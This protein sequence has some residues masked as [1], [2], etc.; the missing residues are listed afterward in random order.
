MDGIEAVFHENVGA[1]RCN[2][3]DLITERS[4]ATSKMVVSSS[5]FG[6]SWLKAL[7][8]KLKFDEEDETSGRWN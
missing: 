8:G 6:F 5:S 4:P 7:E 1:C 2:A 3:R